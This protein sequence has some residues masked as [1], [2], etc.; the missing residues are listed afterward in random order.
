MSDDHPRAIGIGLVPSPFAAM[1]PD[2]DEQLFL[3]LDLG[4]GFFD[5]AVIRK[6]EP[7]CR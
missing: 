3:V 4:G 5:A 7:S 2:D 1:A 6:E